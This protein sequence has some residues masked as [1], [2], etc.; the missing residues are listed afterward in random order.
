MAGLSIRVAG[1]DGP[2]QISSEI[3][4][5]QHCATDTRNRLAELLAGLLT[6]TQ[7]RVFLA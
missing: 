7:I 4:G 6:A 5:H 1:L 3:T 2:G